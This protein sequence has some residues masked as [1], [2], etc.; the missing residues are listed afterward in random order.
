[1]YMKAYLINHKTREP[2]LMEVP[3]L[4]EEPIPEVTMNPQLS[5]RLAT[6]KRDKTRDTKANVPP[7]SVVE[8]ISAA[9]N[10]DELKAVLIALLT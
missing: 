10:L 1:M 5:A 8:L 6:L 4:I 9:T 2:Y 7:A 3:D